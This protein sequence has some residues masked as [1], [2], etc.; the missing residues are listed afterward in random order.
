MGSTRFGNQTITVQYFETVDSDKV[1]KAF[2]G[3]RKRGIYSGGYL[4]RISDISVNISTFLCEIGDTT[5]QVR[6]ET[7]AA[8]TLAVSPSTPYVILRWAYFASASNWMDV[9]AV[10][11]GSIQANDLILGK[12]VFSGS[13]L[14]GFDYSERSNPLVADL[15]LKVE[16]TETASMYLRVRGGRI[17]YGT[18]NFDIADQLS[19]LFTAP[20]SG[21]RVDVLYIDVDGVIKIGTGTPAVPNYAGKIVLAE[22]TI[23]TG[24]TALTASSIKDVRCF[25]GGGGGAQGEYSLEVNAITNKLRLVND[26]SSP[27]NNKYY[28]TTSAGVRGWQNLTDLLPAGIIVNW[29]GSIASIP[30]GWALCNGGSGTPNLTDKFVIGAGNSYA[31]GASGGATTH[32]HH[33]T[34]PDAVYT[35]GAM[36]GGEHALVN[37]YHI[38]YT[39]YESSLPPYYALA[40]IMKIW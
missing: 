36:G 39:D 19:P 24:T 17:T 14:T 12:C 26:A 27:G 37:H 18:Q 1:N 7:A 31:V 33:Y 10:A 4:T 6:V 16:P 23:P 25:L 8:I 40:Y 21:T 2:Q 30:S 5:N 9:F 38:G 29:S 22:I 11:S 32:R 20:G 13:V 3:I 28:G 35:G 15:F 34:T